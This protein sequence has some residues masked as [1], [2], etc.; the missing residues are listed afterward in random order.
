MFTGFPE[1]ALD[2]YDAL[3]MD[4]SRSFFQAHLEVYDTAVLAPMRA[5]TEGLA[6]ELGPAKIYRP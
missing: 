3:A 4:N 2:L 5:L 6:E 1:A